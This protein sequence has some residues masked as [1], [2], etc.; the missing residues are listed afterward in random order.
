[1]LTGSTFLG[2]SGMWREEPVGRPAWP[3]LIAVCPS[4]DFIFPFSSV[5]VRLSALDVTC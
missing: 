1:M 3:H 4:L 2:I 5:S